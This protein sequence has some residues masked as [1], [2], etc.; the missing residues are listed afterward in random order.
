M[1]FI[2]CIVIAGL[3]HSSAVLFLI[4]YPLRKVSLYNNKCFLLSATV[5]VIA[6]TPFLEALNVFNFDI[7]GL[8]NE[9]SA[10]NLFILISTILAF[11]F[12]LFTYKPDGSKN[13]NLLFNLSFIA[14]LMAILGFRVTLGYR[15]LIYFG[16]FLAL[17]VSNVVVQNKWSGNK[18]LFRLVI[19]IVILYML[20]GIPASVFPYHF[21]WEQNVYIDPD[22]KK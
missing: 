16:F 7:I 6:A 14:F 9:G 4:V 22:T 15:V 5:L 12:V 2:L 13:N 17:L 1:P 3:A 21:V 19:P 8:L 11:I 18:V 10:S 20:T